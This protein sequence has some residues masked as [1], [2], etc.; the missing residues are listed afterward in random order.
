MYSGRKWISSRKLIELRFSFV[1][2][3]SYT[4]KGF[5]FNKE[6]RAKYEAPPKKKFKP[7]D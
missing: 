6:N 1:T 4:V 3:R 7:G 2:N 5:V